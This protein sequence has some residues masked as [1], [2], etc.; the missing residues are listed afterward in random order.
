LNRS[1]PLSRLHPSHVALLGQLIRFGLTGGFVTAIHL[2][3]YWTVA[4]PLKITPLIAN[5]VAQII[6]TMLGYTLHSRWSFKG[7]G[8]RDNF[9]RTGG[10]FA[11]VSGIGF[12]LNSL[13]VWLLTGLLHGPVWWPMPAIAIIT[14]LFVFWLNRRWVFG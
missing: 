10:R 13:W 3:I 2:G 11:I 8:T 5:V 12:A 9:T 4:Q 7:H 6:S 14:P 1:S